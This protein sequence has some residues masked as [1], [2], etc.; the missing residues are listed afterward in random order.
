MTKDL[1]HSIRGLLRN[2]GFTAVAV[3]T[4]MLAI[5]VNTTI[6]SVVN[7]VL[8]KALPFREPQQLVSVHK[9]STS[10]DLPGIAAYQYL[11]WKD[12]STNFEDLAA[13]TDDNINLTAN[14]EPERIPYAQVTAS[15]FSTLGVQPLRGR[16]FL[17][18]E[19]KPGA[20]NVV[21]VSE[22]FWQRRY[23][24]DE[25]ILQ[26]SLTLENK[27]Y[28][29]VGVMPNSFRFP[30]EF[31]IWL[32][33]ALDPY[34]ETHSEYFQLVEVVGRLKPDANPANAQTELGLIAQ[35]ASQQEQGK[36]RLPSA[37]VEVTPLHKQ[38]TAGVRSTVL[39]LWGAV[40]LVMLLA[41]VN[42]ASLMVSRT[43]ARQREIAVRAAVGARRWQLIRQ[44]LTES[45][46]IG[47]AGGGLG[48]LLAVW[49]TRGIA[50]LVPKG[51]ATSVYDLNSIRLDW[52][53]F[54]FTFGLSVLTGIVFGL[55]PALTASKPDLIQALRNSRSHGLMSFGLRSFR[56]WLVVTELALA[57]VLLLAAGLLVRSFNK[58]V[59]IDLG[60]DRHDVLTARISLPRS[61]YKDPTQIQAFYDELLQRL[62]S[63]PAV[64]SAGMINHTPLTGFGI[65][66]FTSI[67]GHTQL[68]RGKDSLI[69]IGSV[70]SDYFRTMKIPLLSGR[71][72]DTHD[73]ADGQ[74][75]AIVNQAF[76]KRFFANG[77][78]LGKH[79]GFGCKENEGLCRTIVGVVGNIRQESITDQAAPEMYLPFAQMRM[80]GMTLMVKS[81]SDPTNLA[82]SVRN[83]VLAIDKNQPLFEVQTLAQRIDEG[84]AVSRSLMLLFTAFALLGL[85]LGAVGIYGIVS[86]SVTQRTHEIGIRMALGARAGNVLSLILKNGLALVLT[87]IVIGVGSALMLTRFLATLLFGIEPTDSVTFLVVSATFFLIAMVAASIP[88]LRATRVDPLIALRYE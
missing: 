22:R 21:L 24:R 57:V 43:F 82:R 78:P 42:V 76:A 25:K 62:Q 54:A 16:F 18:D 28:S 11:A 2:P 59:A 9:T 29:I 53:V 79:V 10:N 20:N 80:N 77:D 34:K 86:Y 85:I 56:G 41:C 84:V 15:L 4:L 83:A 1:L 88:A 45:I 39:I 26:Q 19:D 70:S 58:L 48:L 40:G 72:Y 8:L 52:S 14:G 63:L 17:P 74:K 60:F 66:A 31:D 33:L 67:E 73:G 87:G 38:L 37:P 27:P 44:L 81:S 36:E 51:F 32:P 69:G 55:A 47:I 46:V 6:F 64:E 3:I 71:T 35:R 5:G 23:G 61:I 68:D 50:S 65:V 49:G 7:A 12:N 75:V 30:G 13:F